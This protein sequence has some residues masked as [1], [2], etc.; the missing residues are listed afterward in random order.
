MVDAGRLSRNQGGPL[1]RVARQ[2]LLQGLASGQYLPGT[3]LPPEKDLS[4][5][6]GISIGTLRKAVD[7]LVSEG[8]LV[9]Q[10]GRGTFVTSHDRERLL[11][12]FFHMVPH[13]GYK[14]EYPLVTL[15]AF[16]R[17]RLGAEAARKLQ[18][19]GGAMGWHLR[20]VLQLGGH[21]LMV[22]DI[23][24]P[25]SRFPGLTEA[26]VRNRP[27][28]LYQLYQEAYSLSVA[29]TSERLR[30]ADAAEDVASLLGLPAGAAVLV[31]RRLALGYQQDPIEWRIS[32][33]NTR[34]HEYF[35]ELG[36]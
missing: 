15:H 26:E 12:S 14:T 13:D 35:S 30:A 29:R 21:A 23:M 6:Y 11:Y 34:L 10:Q 8:L 1:Y 5:Q 17:Q 19:P 22:D 4:A 36:A 20:N 33:A 3:A 16:S 32:H 9:R 18:Q 25:E 27:G 28:T 24:L 31:I 7:E 2:H